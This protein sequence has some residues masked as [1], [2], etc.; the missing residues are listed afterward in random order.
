MRGPFGAFID[1]FILVITEL[2]AQRRIFIVGDFNIDQT[3]PENVA[4]VDPLIQSFSLSQPSWYSTHIHRGLFR[5]TFDTS[6]PNAV[7][8]LPSPYNDNLVFFPDL[9]IIF[10]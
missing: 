7:F 10:I 6:N 8:S 9:I 5:L 3:L 4:K 1:D 2:P